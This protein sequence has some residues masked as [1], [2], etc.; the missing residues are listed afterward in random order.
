[1]CTASTP[2]CF[3]F[4]RDV[5]AL[6]LM[7]SRDQEWGTKVV[8]AA[9]GMAGGSWSSAWNCGGKQL[10]QLDVGA[11]AVVFVVLLVG[12]APSTDLRVDFSAGS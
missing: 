9:Q 10:R 5:N 11:A 6:L 3:V 4:Q 8:L 7:E 2:I 12:P 1:M